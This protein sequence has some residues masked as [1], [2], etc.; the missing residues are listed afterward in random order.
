MVGADVLAYLHEFAISLS[1]IH[2]ALLNDVRILLIGFTFEQ[3]T[4]I[5]HVHQVH[6]IGSVFPFGHYDD[7]VFSRS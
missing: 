7:D 6:V 3:G 1:Q 5:S 2:A 4:A